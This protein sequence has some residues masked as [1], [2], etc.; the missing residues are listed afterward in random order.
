MKRIIL[1]LSISAL[2]FV[3]CSNPSSGEKKQV[4]DS[5]KEK[6]HLQDS[7]TKIKSLEKIAWGD[8]LFGMTK[9][10][11]VKTKAFQ[12]CYEHDK[13][14]ISLP[15]ESTLNLNL[16]ILISVDAYLKMDELYRVEIKTGDKT[17]NYIDDLETDA[18]KLSNEFEKKYGKPTFTLGR[19]IDMSDFNE[20]DE[21][22]F[23][24]WMVGE[25]IISICFGEV[26]DGCKYYYKVSIYNSDYPTSKGLK[27]EAE[28]QKEI[29]QEGEKMKYQF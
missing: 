29:N 9:K 28:M 17:A 7:I 24:Y 1:L 26:S 10:E 18:I 12:G 3:G 15:Y 11:V 14:H 19:S 16:K 2:F 6:K 8:A 25:K 27:K 23:K 20:G 13:D 22:D 5:L 21:F 4:K